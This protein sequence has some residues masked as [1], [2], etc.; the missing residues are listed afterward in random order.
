MRLLIISILMIIAIKNTL[1]DYKVN[2]YILENKEDVNNES[3]TRGLL[4]NFYGE[5]D[6]VILVFVIMIAGSIVSDEYS[7][8][9][10]KSL[11]IL[12]YKRSKILLSKLIT[13]V[14]ML[15]FGI[16]AMLVIQLIVSGLFFGFSS[17]SVPFVTY[18]VATDSMVVMNVFKYFIILTVTIIPKILLL[19]TLA[20]ALSTI[21]GSTAAAIAITFCGYIGEAIINAI[22]MRYDVKFLN[23]F[24]TTNWNFNELLFGGVSSFKLSLTQ[25]IIICLLYFALMVIVS[26]IVF[27][28]KDIKNI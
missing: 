8:G 25:N 24:V 26:L 18:N 11:L 4:I 13:M 20:F 2:E 9:T 7:K 5:Y 3:T 17:L 27:K 21:I 19:G 14:I 6:F 1:I 10:I 22:A 12:P 23:Y 15:L 28:R 16:F